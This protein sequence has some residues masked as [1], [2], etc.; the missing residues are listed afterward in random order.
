LNLEN[1][2]QPKEIIPLV[3]KIAPVRNESLRWC[4]WRN[5]PIPCEDLFSEVITEEGFCRTF[6][7]LDFSELFREEK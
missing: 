7:I 5:K 3:R 4:N 2:L 6:N 1:K